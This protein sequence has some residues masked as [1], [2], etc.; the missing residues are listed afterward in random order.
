MKDGFTDFVL[1]YR[2]PVTKKSRTLTYWQPSAVAFTSSSS[3]FVC[4]LRQTQ[5]QHYRILKL[6]RCIQGPLHEGT[7][8]TICTKRAFSSLG[9]F[10]TRYITLYVFSPV[11]YKAYAPVVCCT[12]AHNAALCCIHWPN[13]EILSLQHDKIVPAIII[14]QSY[15]DASSLQWACLQCGG[16][17]AL[18]RSHR[19]ARFLPAT[20]SHSSIRQRQPD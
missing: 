19:L 20:Q 13:L 7:L 12:K 2:F 11:R 14:I 1:K 6:S 10:T 15:F 17:A 4:A 3:R 16:C 5:G 9:L 8:S 18:R